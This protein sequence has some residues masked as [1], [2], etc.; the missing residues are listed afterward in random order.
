[1][2]LDVLEAFLTTLGYKYLRLDGTTPVVER[3][4]LVDEFQE[5]EE[6]FVFLLSTKAGGL[7][8]NLTAANTVIIHDL[9][10]NPFNDAQACDRAW[11][12]GQTRPVQVIKLVCKDTIEDVI[13][14]RQEAKLILDQRLQE[15]VGAGGD[16]A[17]TGNSD[18]DDA[19]L[20]AA[21]GVQGD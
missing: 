17:A 14:R 16:A 19:S 4:G 18:E 11:R 6:I 13:Y 12:L 7:G 2:C 3:Q 8:L 15:G 21:V 20:A 10:F 1:M 9:D 5:N